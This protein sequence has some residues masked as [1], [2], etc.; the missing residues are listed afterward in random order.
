MMTRT[1]LVAALLGLGAL[2]MFGWSDAALAANPDVG[3]LCQGV[4]VKGDTYYAKA[5]IRITRVDGLRVTFVPYRRDGSLGKARSVSLSRDWKVIIN[6]EELTASNLVKGQELTVFI[7][8]DRF[9]ISIGGPGA[10]GVRARL[11]AQGQGFVAPRAADDHPPGLDRVQ[12][13][14]AGQGIADRVLVLASVGGGDDRPAALPVAGGRHPGQHQSGRA[15]GRCG[16]FGRLRRGRAR[17]RGGTGCAEQVPAGDG[18][19]I[20]GGAGRRCGRRGQ[21]RS[22]GNP[23]GLGGEVQ[24]L[25]A[26]PDAGRARQGGEHQGSGGRGR[27]R[28]DAGGSHGAAVVGHGGVTR[29]RRG[30]GFSPT[31]GRPRAG[32]TRRCSP[33]TCR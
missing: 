5:T 23:A 4:Y 29:A 24:P 12:R 33:R 31:P 30:R 15:L 26:V 1:R 32:G 18:G 27:A 14:I 13:G 19:R 2:T 28:Q 22:G 25:H 8:Q 20:R 16:D 7:P 6:G 10:G 9:A 3:L 21:R 17:G 11:F